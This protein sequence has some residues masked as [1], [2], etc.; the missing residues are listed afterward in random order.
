LQ[1]QVLEETPL[2]GI[3]DIVGNIEVDAPDSDVAVTAARA[4]EEA[5][6]PLPQTMGV[7][8]GFR[9]LIK[10]CRGRKLV[11]ELPVQTVPVAWFECHVPPQGTARIC[12]ERTKGDAGSVGL[13]V[14]GSGFSAGR[15]FSL[16]IEDESDPRSSCAT[17]SVDMHVLPK[18]Y[19]MNGDESIVV[20]VLGQ[21][22]TRIESHVKCASCGEPTDS[23]D[24]LDF[25]L[26]TYFD[27]RKETVRNRRTIKLN[28]ED[29]QSF[30]V[31]FDLP[32]LELPMELVVD[33]S[34]GVVWQVEYE[35][36][37][38][39]LYQPYRHISAQAYQPPM[40][41]ATP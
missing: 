22:G 3:E 5:G 41:T 27:F 17:Y 14:F 36:P 37:P 19:E 7:L 38:G 18:V 2:P 32:G 15:K 28:W 33:A 1:V 16:G 6:I 30:Q 23:L 31:G 24:P 4:I 20:E 26:D 39:F 13:K 35:F 11:R 9:S 34:S 12:T 29:K 21:A 8:D 10:W 40:W 25:L